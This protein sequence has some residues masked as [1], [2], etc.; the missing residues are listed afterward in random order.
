[1]IHTAFALEK[2]CILNF[3]PL[4]LKLWEELIGT[5]SEAFL[6]NCG[7]SYYWITHEAFL[8]LAE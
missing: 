5:F 3:F 2:L 1:M 7:W 4:L 8:V 6:L